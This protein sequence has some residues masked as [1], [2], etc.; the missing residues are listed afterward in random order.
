MLGTITNDANSVWAGVFV[1]ESLGMVL[2]VFLILEFLSRTN[3]VTLNPTIN[4]RWFWYPQLLT[5]A[6]IGLAIGGFVAAS[7]NE[8]GLDPTPYTQ[9][10]FGLFTALYLIVVYICWWIWRARST[11][12]PDERLLVRCAV[13]RL[14]L[15][16][17]RLAYALIYQI[18]GDRTFSAVK[19]NSTAYLF[20][21][22]F[23]DLAL[24]YV[25]ILAILKVSPPKQH[26]NGD[27]QRQQKW[28]NRYTQL[29]GLSRN[30]RTGKSVEDI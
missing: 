7:Q 17:I 14:P 5:W 10:S 18:T 4:E 24:I 27:G 29:P 11:F 21:V 16:A 12:P 19:G 3:K 6:D 28:R 1:T 22:F 26:P 25:S 8:H 13:V 15:L 9:A 23:P 20:L 30:S 2:L